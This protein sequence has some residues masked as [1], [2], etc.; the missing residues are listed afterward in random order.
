MRT[1]AASALKIVGTL[2][3]GVLVAAGVLLAF[4]ASSPRTVVRAQHQEQD[5]HCAI[6]W[7]LSPSFP[8]GI[9]I[10]ASDPDYSITWKDRTTWDSS[11]PCDT[12]VCTVGDNEGSL[13]WHVEQT[14]GNAAG[15]SSS[16]TW[17]YPIKSLSFSNVRERGQVVPG[18]I[19]GTFRLEG[20]D[21]H[22]VTGEISVIEVTE[23]L[24]YPPLCQMR[25]TNPS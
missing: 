25:T 21:G 8:L 13:F 24:L 11:K 20:E 9:R 6:A 10:I 22:V 7:R 17:K 23:E 16:G 12:I 15:G 19:L 14:M 4:R 3:V 1:S 18:S 5:G 2:L